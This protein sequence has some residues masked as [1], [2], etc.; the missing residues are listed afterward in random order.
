M[1]ILV[2]VKQIVNP[3]KIEY[4]S[5]TK[6]IKR[7][8]QHLM[9]NPADL[10]ALEFALKL[11][12]IYPDSQIYTLSM[13]SLECREKIKELVELGV[14]DAILLSDKR[15]AGSDASSTAYALSFA[16]KTL[17]RFDL[18]LCGEHSLDGETSIVPPQIAQYLGICHI[19]SV[20]DINPKDEG[21]LEVVKK[22][23]N[24]MAK[25]EVK[26]PVLLS[27]K[28]DSNLVRFP[29]LSFM[30]RAHSYEPKVLTLDDLKDIDVK[31]VGLEGSKTAVDGF[32]EE[33]MESTSC[34][35]YEQASASEIEC[36][37]DIILKLI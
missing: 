17:G 13:G 22:I 28:K 37:A 27:V 11:K 2:C 31:K 15:L 23:E 9:N 5:T 16:I 25:F 32:E 3:D 21:T 10:N 8:L 29:K 7:S 1:N 35:I 26:L 18:I 36:L 4:D 12:D 33:M 30:I 34:K 19:A 6:T 20:V 24:V 14:D